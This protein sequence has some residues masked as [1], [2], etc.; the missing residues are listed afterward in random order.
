[1]RIRT[2]LECYTKRTIQK[3]SWCPE[4]KS[5]SKLEQICKRIVELLFNEEFI[6][7]RPKWLSSEETK[8]NLEIDI[9][10]EKLKLC[11]E[12][13]GK[14]HYEYIQ[15]FH[16]TEENF[17]ELQKRDKIKEQLIKKRKLKLIIVPYTVKYNEAL[18]FIINKCNELKVKLGE[19]DKN[20]IRKNMNDF[21][22]TVH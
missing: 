6:R 2:Y 3:G 18:D 4:C 22:K 7:I 19:I 10:N 21:I 17:I 9:Y 15:F 16:R 8:G 20:K 11:I 14:Q 12:V 5:T 1:M 13:N